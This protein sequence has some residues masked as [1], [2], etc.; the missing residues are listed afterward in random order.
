VFAYTSECMERFLESQ[1]LGGPAG[2]DF[3]G[4]ITGANNTIPGPEAER[5]NRRGDLCPEVYRFLKEAGPVVV[6]PGET[7]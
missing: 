3:V 1:P 7:G 6:P 5:G 2:Y 4:R